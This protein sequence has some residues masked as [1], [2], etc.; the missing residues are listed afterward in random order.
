[1]GGLHV[2]DMEIE[3]PFPGGF[4]SLP[5]GPEPAWVG[6]GWMDQVSNLQKLMLESSPAGHVQTLTS[7]LLLIQGDADEEV[8]FQESIGMVRAVRALGRDNVQTFVVPDETHGC[9]TYGHQMQTLEAT[10]AFLFEHLVPG[11]VLV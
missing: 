7:P 10:K 8:S 11:E 1:M 4:R 9:G 5:V 2:I 3:P 6:P